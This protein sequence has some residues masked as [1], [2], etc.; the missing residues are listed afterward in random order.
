MLHQCALGRPRQTPREGGRGR[1]GTA[2]ASNNFQLNLRTYP[3]TARELAHFAQVSEQNVP[4]PLLR[5][6]VRRL[7]YTGEQVL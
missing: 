7:K 1:H 3:R 6:A 4:V 2:R 5:A